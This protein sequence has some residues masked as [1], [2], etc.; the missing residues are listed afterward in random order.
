M[1]LKILF[2]SLPLFLAITNFCMEQEGTER[3]LEE[4]RR[5]HAEKYRQ[6]EEAKKEAEQEERKKAKGISPEEQ[7]RRKELFKKERDAI[8]TERK[9]LKE[10]EEEKKKEATTEQKPPASLLQF[11]QNNQDKLK[12]PGRDEE[13]VKQ[14][15]AWINNNQVT[16]EKRELFSYI[17]SSW[18]TRIIYA[19]L[20]HPG[21]SPASLADNIITTD[22]G[23]LSSTLLDE[24]SAEL[25]FTPFALSRGNI[26]LKYDQMVW[27]SLN[28]EN[29]LKRAGLLGDSLHREGTMLG[30]QL[31]A[32]TD[33]QYL[34][35]TKN[36]D[37][38]RVILFLPQFTKDL[39]PVYIQHF[40][41][42][43]RLTGNETAPDGT[44]ALMFAVGEGYLEIVR[45]LLSQG[46]NPFQANRYG[47]DAFSVAEIQIHRAL[48][49]K[50]KAYYAIY[51][52][53]ATLLDEHAQQRAKNAARAIAFA[54]LTRVVEDPPGTRRIIH[55]LSAELA[56]HI[57]IGDLTA[58]EQQRLLRYLSQ[59]TPQ[60]WTAI[61][62]EVQSEGPVS[63][64]TLFERLSSFLPAAALSY[65][66]ARGSNQ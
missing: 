36:L 44:S 12:T 13:L 61:Y 6:Q 35:N 52:K 45:K 14:I 40:K 1:K 50:N 16:I 4:V 42:A 18:D 30:Y 39:D 48:L 47:D 17:I 31:R 22:W 53:I 29:A 65:Y 64:P 15:V 11:L 51:K 58:H 21:I 60:E 7:A 34:A 37:L 41:E 5:E 49:H 9:R 46:A 19:L 54:M 32:G 56:L 27:R 20:R 10:E 63:T 43:A 57:A 8:E 2:V 26:L 55:G 3:Q 23:K 59:L 25:L 24:L 33:V 38:I 62:A 28:L 66:F